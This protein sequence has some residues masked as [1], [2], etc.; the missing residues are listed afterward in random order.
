MKETNLPSIV[1]KVDTSSLY[2]T[3]FNG[4]EIPNT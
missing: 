1:I 4:D 3:S 2:K